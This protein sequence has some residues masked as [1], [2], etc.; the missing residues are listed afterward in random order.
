MKDLVKDRDMKDD[1][2]VFEEKKE[3]RV[4]QVSGKAYKLGDRIAVRV[5]K[6]SVERGHLDLIPM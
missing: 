3:R 5:I 1:L 4:G 2:Y 6:V